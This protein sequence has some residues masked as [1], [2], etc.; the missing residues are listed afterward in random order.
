[1]TILHQVSVVGDFSEEDIETCILDYLGTVSAPEDL[2]MTNEHSPIT[3]R[4]YPHDLQFQEVR[5]DASLSFHRTFEI[6]S[7]IMH[8]KGLLLGV[9][10]NLC[11]SLVSCWWTGFLEGH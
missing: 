6:E 5:S 1:M 3:Y 2:K 9:S 10:S 11:D 8:L 4:P 7:Y